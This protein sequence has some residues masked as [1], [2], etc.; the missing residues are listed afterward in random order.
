MNSRNPSTSTNLR[1]QI[2][3][4]KLEGAHLL[5]EVLNGASDAIISLD[6]KQRILLFN[7]QAE[8]LF[9]YP[10]EEV[11]GKPLNLLMPK[12]FREAHAVHVKRFATWKTQRRLMS[13]RPDLV[14]LRKNGEEFPVEIMIS[15]T[16]VKGVGIFTAIIRDI[17]ER[18]RT[19]NQLKEYRE[20]LQVLVEERTLQLEAVNIELESFS[21]S[22]SHDLRAPL[23]GIDGFS[24]VLLEDFA[25]RLGSDGQGYLNR[26]RAASQ[27]M[28]KLID[29]LLNLSSM[30]RAELHT[31]PVDLSQLVRDI[32]DDLQRS[33][34]GRRVSFRIAEG[35]IVNGDK[36]LLRVALDNLLG[37][38]W[39]F[40]GERSQAKIEFGVTQ[41]DGKSVYF[42]K[43]DGDG[44]DMA[45]A[46]KLFVAFQRLH[47]ATEFEGTGIGLATVKR[48][49]HRH[50]GRIWA[51]GEKGKGATFYFVL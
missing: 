26:I 25:D 21:Y 40:T 7:K 44:F 6:Y 4:L 10:L 22:V 27:R 35:L 16:K 32:A 45:Y 18:V 2:K 5:Q 20:H 9:G 39:K 37:N 29:D 51:E 17:T 33:E 11:I 38:A 49:I 13:E 34:P 47:R 12:R 30:T 42:V 43:D 46:N 24:K 31:E 28:A 1:E 14:G 23:R 41:K 3:P 15:K 8:V 36:V 19:E 50:G 48:I